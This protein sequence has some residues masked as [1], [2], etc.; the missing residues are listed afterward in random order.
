MSAGCVASKGARIAAS[1]NPKIRIA[2]SN[3]VRSFAS[4]KNIN[5]VFS[6]VLPL[7][8]WI[9]KTLDY[10]NGE[11]YSD[12]HCPRSQSEAHNGIVI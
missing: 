4:L 7:I 5:F 11:V 12:K 6:N 10:I 8:S 1:I 9:D 2:P 3:V